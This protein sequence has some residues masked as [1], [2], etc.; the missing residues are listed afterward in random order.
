MKISRINNYNQNFGERYKTED[1]LR[2]VTGYPYKGKGSEKFIRELT[3]IDMYSSEVKRQIPEKA[4]YSYVIIAIENACEERVTSQNKEFPQIKKD[5]LKVLM[6]AKD[7]ETKRSAFEEILKK[8]GRTI[9]LKPFSLTRADIEKAYK[10]WLDVLQHV[11]E[12][13]YEE[14]KKSINNA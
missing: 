3:G 13:M 4:E 1:V 14:Y 2:L 11:Q 5:F 8:F 7:E 9:E 6:H 12:L 10:D